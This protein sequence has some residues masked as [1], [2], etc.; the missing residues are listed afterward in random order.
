MVG[1]SFKKH[2]HY[3]YSND[4]SLFSTKKFKISVPS[5]RITEGTTLFRICE[6]KG[7][8][9]LRHFLCWE[10]WSFLFLSVPHHI[11]TCGGL[12]ARISEHVLVASG[13][14]KSMLKE[15]KRK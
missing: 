15:K 5:S 10:H 11:S 12:E 9:T 3:F 4:F 6:I 2:V 1:P 13:V 14:I 8:V 7:T